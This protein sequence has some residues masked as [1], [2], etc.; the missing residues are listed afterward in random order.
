MAK[1]SISMACCDY[2]RTRALFDGRVTVEGCD[3]HAVPIE[4]EEA[5]HRGFKYNEFDVSELSLSSHTMTTARGDNHYVAIPAFVS[6]LFRHSGFYIRTDRGIDRPG[7][8]R[9]KKIGLPEYQMT[10][11]VW[12]RGI[13]EDEYGVRPADIH[14]RR[15]GLEEPGREERSPIALPPD[16]DLQQVPHDRTLSQM[17]EAGELDGVISARAPACFTKGAPHIAR[18]FPDYP[19]A[20]EAYYRRTAIFPIMHVIG[21]RRSLLERHPWLAVS[22]LKAFIEAKNLCMAE[23]GQI[24]HLFTSLPWAVAEFHRMQA[25]MGEDYWSYGVHANRKVLETF[26]RYSFDQGLS[27]RHVTLEDLFAGPTFDLTKI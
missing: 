12:M 13:L 15:G 9:G 11:N 25:L 16:I 19:A 22:F 2:D 23:M 6:R 26:T 14:W 10:A 3:V 17:L 5:F 1:L 7:D 4:P 21:I 20:E 18:L 27:A 24:G 8:L